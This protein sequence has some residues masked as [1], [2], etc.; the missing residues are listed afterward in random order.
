[1]YG[2]LH[3][4]CFRNVKVQNVAINSNFMQFLGKNF[5][6]KAEIKNT[7]HIFFNR[8]LCQETSGMNTIV[9]W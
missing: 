3:R 2:V 7:K 4:K 8:A 6:N 5:K 9:F 1:M